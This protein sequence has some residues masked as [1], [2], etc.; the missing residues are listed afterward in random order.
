MLLEIEQ[1]LMQTQ[2]HMK[3]LRTKYSKNMATIEL[4]GRNCRCSQTKHRSVV[5]PTMSALK[6]TSM[7]QLTNAK[8]LVSKVV[9]DGQVVEVRHCVE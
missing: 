9:E 3:H 1:G 6:Q 4:Q 2:G 8:V 5:E 7:R